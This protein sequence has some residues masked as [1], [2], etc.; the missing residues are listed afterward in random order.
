MAALKTGTILENTYQIVEEIGSG[1]GGIV[2]RAKHLRLDTDIVVKKIKD[3]VF[4]KINIEQEAKILKNLKHSYLP[5]VYDF[6]VA[7]DGVYTVMDFIHGENL[8][9]AVRRHGKYSQKQVLR[10]AEQLGEALQYLHGQKPPIIHSD[11]KPAN[12]MIT[13]EGNLCLIDF[14]IALALGGEMESAVGVSAGFSPPEQYRDPAVYARFTGNGT[15]SG[16]AIKAIERNKRI[17]QESAGVKTE[18][19]TCQTELEQT[20]MKTELETCGPDA[21]KTELVQ[22]YGTAK[23]ELVQESDADKT[24]MEIQADSTISSQAQNQTLPDF[25]QFFGR[26]VDT[27]SDIYSLGITLYY[28]LTGIAPAV[29][30][31]RRIPVSKTN[32]TISEGLAVILEKMTDLFPDKRYQ[33]GREFLRAVRNCSRLDHRY[34]VMH[35]KQTGLQMAALAFLGCGILTISLGFYKMRAEKNSIYYNL[36]SQAQEVMS[37]NDY[38]EAEKLLADAKLL[39]E[40]RVEAYEEEVCLLFLSGAYEKCISSGITYINTRPFL[41]ETEEDKELF[42]NIYYIVGNAYFEN[43]DYS[44]ARVF[45][46]DALEYNQRNGL[47]Y[48]DYAIT[49]AKLGQVEKAQRQLEKGI[50]LGIAQDSIYMAQGEIAHVE[51]QGEEAIEYFR[52]TIAISSD[53]QMVR[54][55]VLFCAETYKAMGRVDEEIALLEQYLAQFEGN[56]NIVMLEKL[57]DAYVHKAQMDETQADT[58]YQKALTFF[59]LICDKGHITYQIQENMAILYE[60]MDSFDEA[61][62]LLQ[63]MAG[64]YPQRYEIYKRLAYLE[65]DRQQMKENE[66][67]DYRQMQ[68]YYEQAKERYSPKE[69]DPEMDMLDQMM[70]DLQAGGWF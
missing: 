48:R 3:E 50:N 1:G 54:R 31:D 23:T 66:E 67:R 49:L 26:G 10:W 37:L 35:R 28:L 59:Q 38:Q 69:Q 46:E 18:L 2:F 16:S 51:G 61:E 52:Q 43:E 62:A 6:I 57:A 30:F 56:G 42:G 11:I 29:D 25:T 47:Y 65:A 15:V 68:L 41:L 64:N 58:C 45:F 53:M 40:T 20:G 21:V 70:Q 22:E 36:I 55:A 63:Q 8:D 60:Y 9:E 7:E 39:S 34:I 27:R 13:K 4:G 33:N 32:I 19:E 5:K 24:E 14:N 12:I 17:Q 44:N